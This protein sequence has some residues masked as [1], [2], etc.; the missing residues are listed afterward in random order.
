MGG[1]V[2]F[3]PLPTWCRWPALALFFFFLAKG[4]V[5]LLIFFF[6]YTY[7]K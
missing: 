6:G 5:W 2:K 4:L 3:C 7:F 1:G